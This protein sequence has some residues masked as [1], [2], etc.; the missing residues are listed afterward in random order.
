M[1]DRIIGEGI[2]FD[3]V[4]L[5]PGY[6]EVLGSDVDVTTRLSR[7][8]ALNVPVVSSAMDT[9]TESALAIAMAQQGG[10]GFIH[11]NLTIEQQV[12]EVYLVKRSVNGI[13]TDPVTLPPSE[14]V[15]TARRLMDENRIS[16]IPI[17]SD[18]KVVG[19]LTSRDLRF[20]TEDRAPIAD[21]MTKDNLVTGAPDTTLEA[22]KDHLHRSKVEKLL[23]V[24]EDMTLRGLIT[25]KDINKLM[26]FP[27][28]NL[29]EQGRL[30][31]GAA[32]GAVGDA[33]ERAAALIAQGV[34][35]LVV[36]T[37]HG[38]SKNVGDTVRHLKE[39]FPDVDVVA[40]NVAT[41][42]AAKFLADRG[43]DAV[44]VGIGPGSI[45]T[46]RIVAGI[47]VPQL[48]AIADSVK[49]LE[50]TGVPVIADGGI[51]YSGDIVKAIAAGAHCAMVGSLFA[52]TEE[53][54][55]EMI[56]YRGRSFK[57]YRGMGSLGAMARG[58]KD[59]YG[60]QEIRATEKF[61]PEGVEGRVPYKGPLSGLVHQLV[62]GL[63][64]GMGY[65][66]T[67]DI[68]KL[69]S[70]SRF[71]R[72]SGAGVTESHPHDIEITKEAPNYRVDR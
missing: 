28:A 67:T 57:T 17:V 60:Q 59:R 40:G 23:L 52:G 47:G 53:S 42:E 62:G 13:I 54:P 20:R 16:G 46:T 56:L 72:V 27:Q 19:I 2:T 8:V 64:Q 44:K 30:R 66:G 33:R 51:R 48:S 65:C 29:D 41:A 37:A 4:L 25:I 10:L 15:G 21:V 35:V 7:R 5:L 11:K 39:N 50:G 71:M 9:V 61:V 18:R 55:G 31:A 45:C 34:D 43:A 63:R 22:A 70:E 38:H 12:H 68:E 3:D 14:S 24:D 1:Q 69:R 26:E 49:G 58:S 36:D 6:S 32:V